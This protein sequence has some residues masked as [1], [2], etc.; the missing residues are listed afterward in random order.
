MSATTVCTENPKTKQI[1]RENSASQALKQMFDLMR[2]EQSIFGSGV[3]PLDLR[4]ISIECEKPRPFDRGISDESNPTD[5]SLV[6]MKN[7]ELDLRIEAK[8][9]LNEAEVKSDYLSTSGLR[10]FDDNSLS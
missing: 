7:N 1:P 8:T 10:R 3:Q 6:L 9:I 2:A 5:L 4:H